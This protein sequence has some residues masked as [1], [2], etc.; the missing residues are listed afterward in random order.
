MQ[1]FVSDDVEI[2]AGVVYDESMDEQLR[3]TLVVACSAS[4]CYI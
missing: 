1:E 3:V 2:I 4:T